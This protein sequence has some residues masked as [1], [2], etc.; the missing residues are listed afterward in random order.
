MC[1]KQTNQNLFLLISR[2]TVAGQVQLPPG[3]RSGRGVAKGRDFNPDLLFFFRGHVSRKTKR[4]VFKVGFFCRSKKNAPSLS[5]TRS[6]ARTAPFGRR[7]DGSDIV[8]SAALSLRMCT[9]TRSMAHGPARRRSGSVCNKPP[10]HGCR[11]RSAGLSLRAS[12]LVLFLACTA[13]VDRASPS[14][15]AANMDGE[16]TYREATE[17]CYSLW[18]ACSC[19]GCCWKCP[20]NSFSGSARRL[21]LSVLSDADAMPAHPTPRC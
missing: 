18:G 7:T 12:G 8:S 20:A 15:C 2:N 9:G 11:W 5:F 21:A 14:P 10:T 16:A 19:P 4:E 6:R 13:R 1:A 3:V 17:D